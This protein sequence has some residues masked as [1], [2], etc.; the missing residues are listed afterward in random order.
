LFSVAVRIYL[1]HHAQPGGPIASLTVCYC[2]HSGLLVGPELALSLP[3]KLQL[4]LVCAN[5]PLPKCLVC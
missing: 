4:P 5:K 2:G 1:Q 3:W